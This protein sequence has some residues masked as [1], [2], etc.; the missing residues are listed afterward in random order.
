M[1]L[2]GPMT[3]MTRCPGMM[4]T[5]CGERGQGPCVMDGDRDDTTDGDDTVIASGNTLRSR[6]IGVDAE[7]SAREMKC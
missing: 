1:T 7:G 3:G 4:G 2:L 5:T 6:A